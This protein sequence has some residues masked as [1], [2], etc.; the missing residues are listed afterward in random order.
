MKG[1]FVVSSVDVE[2]PNARGE[3]RFT[4]VGQRGGMTEGLLFVK[5]NSAESLQAWVK[6]IRNGLNEEEARKDATEH[7][8]AR[9][10]LS[11]EN[12]K[13]YDTLQLVSMCMVMGCGKIVDETVCG[14][15]YCADHEHHPVGK[16]SFEVVR[17]VMIDIRESTGY[18]GEGWDKL[19]TYMTIEELCQKL[20]ISCQNGKLTE[21]GF[22]GCNLT[23]TPPSLDTHSP[24]C[25]HAHM[26]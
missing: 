8:K 9:K 25:K 12:M 13:G 7:L 4:M 23:G 1:T 10:V 15:G 16:A 21:L 22:G 11:D 24:P 20:E 6:F 2:L 19:E 18:V 3:H 17:Q 5:T 14:S 26:S